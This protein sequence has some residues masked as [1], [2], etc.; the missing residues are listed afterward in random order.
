MIGLKTKNAPKPSTVIPYFIASSVSLLLFSVIFLIV[1]NDF[2]IDYSSPRIIALTHTVTIGI[3]TMIMMGTLHQFV[4]VVF[5]T[6]I[7]SEKIAFLNFYFFTSGMLLLVYS[8]YYHLYIDLLPISTSIVS[9]SIWLF[10]YN[11]LATYRQSKKKEISSLFIVT[12]LFWLFITT[13]YGLLQ[14]FNFRYNYLHIFNHNYLKIHFNIGII[15][16]FLMLLIGVS[17]IILP[18][19]LISHRFVDRNKLKTAY[20]SINFGLIV[21]W[22]NWQINNNVI[23]TNIGW[24]LIIFGISQYLFYIFKAFKFKKKKLDIA[25]KHAF[26]SFLIAIVPMVLSLI[27]INENVLKLDMKQSL[28]IYIISILLGVFLNLFLGITYRTLPFIA[29][30]YRFQKYVGKVKVPKP[31]ELYNKILG[32]IQFIFYLFMFINLILGIL[33]NNYIYIRISA[34][35]MVLISIIFNINTINIILFKQNTDKDVSNTDLKK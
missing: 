17:S 32:N 27:I 24:I 11:I 12:S 5:D 14:A 26:S 28:F 31:D 29:W 7:R 15:G 9:L 35:L 20:I 6:N 19:F 8:F 23:I 22:I 16:W 10:I 2:L 4:P 34:F 3:L 13:I 18:M 21:L 33:F 30:L 25:M 1:S